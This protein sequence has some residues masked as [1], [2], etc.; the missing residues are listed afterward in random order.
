MNM[1]EG[2]IQKEGLVL[3]DVLLHKVNRFI[4]ISGCEIL[5]I[6]RLLYNVR[7]LKQGQP[8]GT[9]DISAAHMVVD[10]ATAHVVG[11]AEPLVKSPIGRQE[12]LPLAQMP[13]ADN[14]GGISFIS[15][16]FGQRRFVGE[17]TV[18]GIGFEYPR[19]DASPDWISTG[20]QRRSG[21]RTKY[22]GRVPVE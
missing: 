5:Q 11:N 16:V 13:L 18:D 3:F 4:D 14:L 2:Q 6:D 7:P 20:Q 1:R 9:V 8:H 17:Q 12:L 22:R 19:I 21:G 10:A 15:Q